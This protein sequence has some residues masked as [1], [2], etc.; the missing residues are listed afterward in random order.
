M[1][2]RLWKVIIFLIL[3]AIDAL[4]QKLRCIVI[5]QECVF[6]CFGPD[7]AMLGDII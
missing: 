6:A 3:H 2:V 7:V 4:L 1:I 5:Y